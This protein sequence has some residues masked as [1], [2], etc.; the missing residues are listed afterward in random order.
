[1]KALDQLF[2]RMYRWFL[3]ELVRSKDSFISSYK[4]C[5]SFDLDKLLEDVQ[6]GLYPIT[7]YH[8]LFPT[9]HTLSLLTKSSA[10]DKA[11]TPSLSFS[12]NQSSATATDHDS[13]HALQSH[14]DPLVFHSIDGNGI[15]YTDHTG[16]TRLATAA[17]TF[18][19]INSAS[20]DSEHL[21][22]DGFSVS[23]LTSTHHISSND[24]KENR[25]IIDIQCKLKTKETGVYMVMIRE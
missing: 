2:L 23:T 21:D 7:A 13:F 24:E 1:M 19:R 11:L 17:N 4:D 15:H 16:K 5:P 25:R 10:S 12:S 8:L 20:L 14:S 9:H 22:H 6:N 18:E 3:I